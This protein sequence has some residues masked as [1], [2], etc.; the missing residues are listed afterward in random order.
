MAQRQ[1][2]HDRS[3]E[4]QQRNFGSAMVKC[5]N[6]GAQTT[7]RKSL[8]DF[9]LKDE[10]GK[11]CRFCLDCSEAFERSLEV[12]NDPTGLLFEKGILV[13]LGEKD[14]FFRIRFQASPGELPKWVVV[15][16]EDETGGLLVFVRKVG[17][18][19]EKSPD[20]ATR[21]TSQIIITKK[22]DRVAFGEPYLSFQK[23]D[24]SEDEISKESKEETEEITEEKRETE[25]KNS[26]EGVTENIPEEIFLDENEEE[27]GEE[28]EEE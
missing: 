10:E 17:S 11:Y 18:Y 14:P 8:S 12:I 16:S 7:R 24:E 21:I 25:K 19:I 28:E 20:G 9:R 2:S 15:P 27:E 4:A 26:K 1:D 5:V 22:S 6:C 13:D 23:K 3:R